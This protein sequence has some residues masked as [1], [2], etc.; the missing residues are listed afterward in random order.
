MRRDRIVA[1]HRVILLHQV[2]NAERCE[3]AENSDRDQDQVEHLVIRDSDAEQQRRD[4]GADGQKDEAWRERKQQRF[5][6][7]P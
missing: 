1:Q 7:T 5:H 4:D 6:E 3:R 2:A